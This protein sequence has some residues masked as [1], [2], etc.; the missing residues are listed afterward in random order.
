MNFNTECVEPDPIK[1]NYYKGNYEVIREE[2]LS[3]D[4]GI[5]QDLSAHDGYRL[6]CDKVQTCVE[7]YI[8]L[9]KPGSKRLKRNKWM[10]KH[11]LRSV[12]LKYKAWKKYVHTRHAADFEKYRK[13]R[14]ICTNTVRNA[15]LNSNILLL[16]V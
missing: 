7:K 10:D 4:W 5:L 13:L 8:L 16:K 15:K 12:K 1:R 3:T 2:L 6:F 14:N 9:F 11:C